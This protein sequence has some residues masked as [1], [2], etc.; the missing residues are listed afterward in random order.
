M[1]HMRRRARLPLE[2]SGSIQLQDLFDQTDS[3]FV[4]F[5]RVQA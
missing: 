5:N 2:N 4:R 1:P 3:Q